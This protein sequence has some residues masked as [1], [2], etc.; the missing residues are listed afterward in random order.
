MGAASTLSTGQREESHGTI[1]SN[2]RHQPTAAKKVGTP[3]QHELYALQYSS[4]KRQYAA[5][6]MCARSMTAWMAF[7]CV[8]WPPTRVVVL[9]ILLGNNGGTRQWRGTFTTAV[10]P[11]FVA[12]CCG[13]VCPE[14]PAALPEL[15]LLH[16][17]KKVL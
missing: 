9:E 8:H 1:S 16:L 12:L 14:F 6:Q 3:A 4:C 15:M 2:G 7:H 10:E 5:H 11:Y 13:C 17:Q